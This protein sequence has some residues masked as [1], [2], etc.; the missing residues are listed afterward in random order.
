MKSDNIKCEDNF[1]VQ[2]EE[3]ESLIPN[4]FSIYQNEHSIE[5]ANRKKII[6]KTKQFYDDLGISFHDICQLNFKDYS[7]NELRQMLLEGTITK[8]SPYD[9]PVKISD[10]DSYVSILRHNRK[11]IKELLQEYPAIFGYINL[12]RDSNRYNTISYTHELMHTQLESLDSSIENH[13]NSEVFSIFFELLHASYF[14]KVLCEK[15]YK[16]RF[17]YLKYAIEQLKKAETK[18]VD[19]KFNYMYIVS[20]LKAVNLI[21]LYINGNLQ[22]EI[23]TDINSVLDGNI[24]VE[25]MLRKNNVDY[26]NSKDKVLSL[27]K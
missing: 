18:D 8:S 25:D 3:I 26:N 4:S 27:L 9:I 23:I 14:D 17:Y 2:L 11:D 5:V 15:A 21:D 10:D 13:L 12:S 22:D 16:R 7:S 6:D 24:S 19:K 20:T 1:D